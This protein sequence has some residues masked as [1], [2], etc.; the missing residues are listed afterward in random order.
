MLIMAPVVFVMCTVKPDI[1]TFAFHRE[2]QVHAA[3]KSY[4]KK[5]ELTSKATV[6]NSLKLENATSGN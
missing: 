6:R 1:L 2:C 4:I 3:V 5:K